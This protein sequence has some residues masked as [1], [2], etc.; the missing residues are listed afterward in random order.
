MARRGSRPLLIGL[1]GNICT[2]KSTVAG[3]LAELGAEVID[4]DLVAHEVMRAG[5]PIH[6]KIVETFG[7]GVLAPN[8]EID[9]TRLGAIV[10]AD[11]AALARL[12]AIVHPATIEAVVQRIAAASSAVVVVEAIKLIESGM[13]DGCDSVWVTTCR[14][15]QQVYR[16]MGGRGLSRAEAWQRVRAQPPQ[17]EKIAR[18]DVVI[19]TSG[20]LPQTRAQV[21]AAWQ[22]LVGRVSGCNY[23][24]V[25]GRG[26]TWHGGKKSQC[27]GPK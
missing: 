13:A 3:M 22:K 12:E 25:L 4:A 2:G 6:A 5:T 14:P 8:G 20:T 1:T 21:R 26:G 17:E 18:A 23:G 24:S 7:P 16:I 10:F 15:E 27:D 9:R 19:D 11:P